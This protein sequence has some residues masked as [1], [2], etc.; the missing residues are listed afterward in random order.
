MQVAAFLV[1]GVATHAVAATGKEYSEAD[2]AVVQGIEI[3]SSSGSG[4][5]GATARKASKAFGDAQDDVEDEGLQTTFGTL[6]RVFGAAGRAR[7][8]IGAAKAIAKA[9][10]SGKAYTKALETWTNA[11]GT[12]AIGSVRSTATSTT[13]TTEPDDE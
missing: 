2:C 7:T 3:D 13:S 12:C 6:S 4:Y 10:K 11:L 1:V 5:Y 9:D 8:V